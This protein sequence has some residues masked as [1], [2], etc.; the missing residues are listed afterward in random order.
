MILE[1]FS[2]KKIENIRRDIDEQNVEPPVLP[3]CSSEKFQKFKLLSEKEVRKLVMDS[4][5][6]SCDLDPIPTDLLKQCIDVLLPVLTKMINISLQSGVFPEEWKLALVIPLIKKLGLDCIFPNYRP[7]SNLPFVGKLTER[8]VIEQEKNHMDLHCPLPI[9]SSAYRQGHSTETALVKVQSDILRNMEN[10]NVTLL[11]LIDLS[12]AFDTVDHGIVMDV[13]RSKYG[14]CG[15]ALEWHKSYLSNRKQ[16]VNLGGIRS[17]TS[18]LQFGLPQGSCLGPV[19]FTQYASTLFEVIHQHLDSAHGY[20]DDHQLYVAFSPNSVTSQQCA[21]ST[22]ENCLLDVKSWMLEYKLKMNDGK[23]E[24]IVIGSRQQ[25]EKIQFD[26]IRVGE[27]TV[28]AVDSVR[29]LGAYLDSQMSM[30]THIEN[31]CKAAF[32]QLYNLRRIR[33]YL[34]QE[35]TEML[36]HSFIFSHIDY[37]NALLYNLPKYQIAKLQR[38]QNMAAKLILRQPK[39]SH[40]TPLLI[41]LH[42]L[43]VE[44]RIQ[45]KLLIL[46]FKGL[47][48]MAP[49]YISNMFVV[50]PNRYSYRSSTSIQDITYENGIVKDDIQSSQVIYLNVPKTHRKTFQDRSLA[51]AGP[52]LWNSLPCAIRMENDFE[53]FKKM[54]KTHLFK[55]AYFM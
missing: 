32:K 10:Q 33:K 45:F 31:K 39:F 22:M 55:C 54:L 35:A 2:Y 11:V 20:A 24:F 29:D 26:S 30:E 53:N 16:C 3:D 18:E 51:V 12:A 40:V 5:T 21:L 48:N 34:S 36:V 23:T 44:Q 42:W 52:V 8:A 28:T 13:L 6:T 41:Q 14:I 49:V 19:M 47:H 1:G 46:T 38:I 9:H 15:P 4:K 17:E 37:C 50:K 25:L 27:A 7:V 43:P